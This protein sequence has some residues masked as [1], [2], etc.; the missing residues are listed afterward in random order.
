MTRV[1]TWLALCVCGICVQTTALRAQVVQLLENDSVRV[2]RAT[3]RAGTSTG[4][5][6]HLLPHVTYVENGGTLLIRHPD[7][8]ADTVKVATGSA[9]WGRVETHTADNIGSSDVVL[10]TVELKRSHGNQPPN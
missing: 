9:Y 4:R 10:I 7:G 8:S 1:I 3:I 5:H 6:T 2:F